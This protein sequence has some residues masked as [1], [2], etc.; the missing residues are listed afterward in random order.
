VRRPWRSQT[1]VIAIAA[2]IFDLLVGGGTP[3]RSEVKQ[4]PDR[5]DRPEMPRILTRVARRVDQLARPVQADNTI[6]PA[7]EDSEDRDGLAIGT[8]AAIVAAKAVVR[9]R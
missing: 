2:G 8:I 7:L 6:R 3:A 9:R 5:L 4:G 1:T